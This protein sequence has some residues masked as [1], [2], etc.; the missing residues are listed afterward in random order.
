MQYYTPFP[1][2]SKNIFHRTII[3]QWPVRT[4]VQPHRPLSRISGTC[5]RLQVS[6]QGQMWLFHLLM[7]YLLP[8]EKKQLDPTLVSDKITY[9]N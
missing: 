8:S 6:V 7:D 3:S 1:S 9:T 5:D 2:I 4:R